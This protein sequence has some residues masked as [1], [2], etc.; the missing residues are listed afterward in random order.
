MPA[1]SENSPEFKYTET[2]P[3]GE[4]RTGYTKFAEGDVLFAKITPCME[5]GKGAVARNLENEIGCGTT[6]LFVLRPKQDVSADYI[7]RYLAQD[8]IRSTNKK[9]SSA[10]STSFSNSPTRSKRVTKRPEATQTN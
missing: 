3:Y 2:R 1:L 10:V 7:Y 6:E 5:N 4:V 8:K 9:K